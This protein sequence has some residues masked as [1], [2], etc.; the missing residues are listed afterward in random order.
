VSEISSS[1][2]ITYHREKLEAYLRNEQ[3]LPVTLELDLSTECNR[4]CPLCPSTTSPRSS[5]LDIVF[6]ERLFA[7]LKGQTRGLLLSGGEPTLAPVFSDVLRLAREYG[8]ID[9]AIVTN[10][11]FLDEEQVA[12]ALCTYATTI[13]VSMYDWSIESSKYLQATL[14]RIRILRERI[15]NE[16]S[17]LQIGTSV[18]TSKDNANDL[19]SIVQKVASAGA[20]WIYFHPMC[21]RWDTGAP[22]RV[23]QLGVLSI[24][25]KCQQEQPENFH[26]YTFPERYIEREIEF[27]AYH[28]AHFLLVVGADGMNYLG[29]EVKYHAKYVIADLNDNWCDDFL[30]Q[31]ERLKRI[32]SI[33]SRTYPAVGSRHRGVLYNQVLQDLINSGKRSLDTVVMTSGATY[34][35]PHI[36]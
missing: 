17:K 22:E 34:A 35:Y 21:I 4:K 3:V 31:S 9:I 8:F 7:R 13:R 11:S 14:R 33:N 36:L 30:W 27:S 15:E 16:K 10:G 6:V 1:H 26:V 18:L 29:A 19:P 23:N 5:N 2:K 20:H 25:K 12:S 24:I 32:E 28:A